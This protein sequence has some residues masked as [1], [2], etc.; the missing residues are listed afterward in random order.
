MDLYSDLI[1]SFS[2][3][4]STNGNSLLI[5]DSEDKSDKNN[6]LKN[7]IIQLKN[8]NTVVDYINFNNMIDVNSNAENLANK[9]TDYHQEMMKRLKLINENNVNSIYKINNQNI[10]SKVI[11]INDLQEF[12]YCTKYKYIDII[13]NTIASIIRLGKVT[14]FTIIASTKSL[15]SA[16]IGQSILNLLTTNLIILGNNLNKHVD[17]I[18]EEIK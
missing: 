5:Y 14:G 7:I 10:E 4:I 11:L 18:L 3:D 13:R 6:L 17:E 1:I 15:D 9:L 2:K 8:K 12:L 16:L